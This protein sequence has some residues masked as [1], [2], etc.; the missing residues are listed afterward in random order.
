[1]LATLGIDSPVCQ[2]TISIKRVACDIVCDYVG[3]GK[4][5]NKKE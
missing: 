5:V 4:Q 3:S 2:I 1:V